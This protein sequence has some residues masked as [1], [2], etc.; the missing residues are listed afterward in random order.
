MPGRA[1]ALLPFVN[2]TR[3]RIQ[4]LGSYAI[5]PGTPIP[6]IVL[7]QVGYLAGIILKIEGTITQTAAGTVSPFGHS[8]LLN[9]VRVSANLGSA[10]IVDL[11]GPSLDKVQYWTAPSAGSLRNTYAN[12]IAANPLSY[13]VYVPINANDRTLLQLGLI[14]LQAEQI[15]VTLDVVPAAMN[16]FLTAGGGTITPAL[17]LYV[18]YVY[19]DV[20]NPTRYQQPA[21]TIQRLLEDSFPITNTGDQ[22]YVVPRLGTL[23]QMTEYFLFNGAN[24]TL[25]TN[26][27]QINAARLRANKTDTWLQYDMRSK[28]IEEQSFYNTA[29]GSFMV[30]GAMTWDFFH[31][32]QQT[33]NFGDRDLINTEKITTLES[34]VTV[35]PSVTITGLCTRTIVRRVFQA[36]V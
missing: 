15:R 17:T 11:S 6:S 10:A 25:S 3:K 33:R 12:A 16:A 22:I 29:S 36:L 13:G 7:P 28:E 31:S 30:P 35:D 26:P 1:P 21:P 2:G 18:S 23:A 20:P 27:P 19:W 14:N 8:A 34:I 4:P 5:T 9:R 24:A 32:G